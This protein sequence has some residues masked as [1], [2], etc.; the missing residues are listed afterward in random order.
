MTVACASTRQLSLAVVASVALLCAGCM[1]VPEGVKRQADY[2]G[3]QGIGVKTI[4]GITFLVTT[5]YVP[6]R[7]VAVD[8]LDKRVTCSIGWATAEVAWS[9]S[10]IDSDDAELVCKWAL[11]GASYVEEF[12]RGDR[13]PAIHYRLGL[14]PVGTGI[15][16][17]SFSWWPLGSLRP[18]FAA[19]W[20]PDDLDRTRAYVL[21][22]FAHESVHLFSGILGLG[23]A[24]N[25][26]VAYLAG[27]CA[28]LSTTGVLSKKAVLNAQMQDHGQMSRDALA[29]N[30]AAVAVG[31][32]LLPYFNE[33]GVVVRTSASGREL[34]RLC[35]DRLRLHFA[36]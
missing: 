30:R 18:E 29:S 4:L 2:R 14:V 12:I 17:H 33:S 21:M 3:A 24:H 16:L 10:R 6:G 15:E 28:I 27:A 36:Q 8:P 1:P 11:S 7:Q 26:E 25:E 13:I 31:Q 23:D 22:T 5:G 9:D 19:V 32:E 35:G 20:F 34:A